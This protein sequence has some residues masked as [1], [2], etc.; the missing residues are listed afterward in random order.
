MSDD[1]STFREAYDSRTGKKLPYLVPESHFEVFPYLQKT[2]KTKAAA[3]KVAEG[4]TPDQ[5]VQA[6]KKGK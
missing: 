2:P 5:A 3:K 4:N 1:F 6:A